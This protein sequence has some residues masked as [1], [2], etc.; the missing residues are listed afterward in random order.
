MPRKSRSLLTL[1]PLPYRLS[2]IT[3]AGLVVKWTRDEIEKVAKTSQQNGVNR[4]S[5]TPGAV[6]LA[7]LQAA[8]FLLLL[9]FSVASVILLLEIQTH[10]HHCQGITEVT[11][12][13]IPPV[14]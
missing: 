13:R 10:H 7:H 11:V 3:S 5:K 14:S 8:F 6:T 4:I 1:I 12:T 9:G 2:R